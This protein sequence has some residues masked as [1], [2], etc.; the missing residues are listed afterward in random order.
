MLRRLFSS[1]NK[2]T[3]AAL[4][5]TTSQ[6]RNESL[7]RYQQARLLRPNSGLAAA[8]SVASLLAARPANHDLILVDARQNPPIVRFQ[9]HSEAFKAALQRREAETRARLANKL[10]ELHLT[11]ATT[12][13]DLGV[14]ADKA[15]EWLQKGWR[16][17]V[18]I[19][20]KRRRR[21]VGAS[22]TSKVD[23]RRLMLTKL[24][25][26]LEGI[27]EQSGQVE[28]EQGQLLSTLAPTAKIL[29]QLKRQRQE[30]ED[31][32]RSSK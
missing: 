7:L 28:V 20:E 18:H 11:T 15:R 25:G 13:H 27:G 17:Q 12:D 19:E 16:V 5:S 4:T 8:E 24:L 26:Q 3:A 30:A 2:A 6:L 29:A 14:K 32:E 10:K 31:E 22:L 23:E 21:P 1:L 9:A